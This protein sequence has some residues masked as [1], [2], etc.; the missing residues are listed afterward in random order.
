M[1]KVEKGIPVAAGKGKYPFREMEVGDS[2]A[3]PSGAASRVR[4]A[5]AHWGKVNSQKFT[6][7]GDGDAHRCWRIA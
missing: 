6:V 4:I 7:K 2:F 5:A 1:F 3:L